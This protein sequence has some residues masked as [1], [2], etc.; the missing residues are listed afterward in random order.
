MA[1]EPYDTFSGGNVDL[2]VPYIGYD[3]NSTTFETAG[4]SSYDALQAQITK[5]MTHGVQVGASYTW[6][7]TLDEQSDVGLFFTGDNPDNLRES[8]ASAD[9]DQTHTLTL[10]L[11]AAVAER[12]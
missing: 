10:Q 9:F 12:W 4:I 11:P 5:R 7:H 1:N 6:S 8:Y 2:R 3:P